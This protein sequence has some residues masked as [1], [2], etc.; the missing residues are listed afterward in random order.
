M[1]GLKAF[2]VVV[3]CDVAHSHEGCSSSPNMGLV[4]CDV[5]HGWRQSITTPPQCIDQCIWW[6]STVVY[7]G[8]PWLPALLVDS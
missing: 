7:I 3:R 2:V 6:R 1:V 8:G 5:H 4:V